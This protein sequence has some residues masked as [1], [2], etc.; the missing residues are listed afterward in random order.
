MLDKSVGPA[1]RLNP[2]GRSQYTD[3]VDIVATPN[4]SGL[5]LKNRLNRPPVEPPAVLSLFFP[6]SRIGRRC[7]TWLWTGMLGEFSW[8]LAAELDDPLRD[9]PGTEEGGES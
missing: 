8:G 6:E 1:S 3:R 9:S 4:R 5:L 2:S 7:R